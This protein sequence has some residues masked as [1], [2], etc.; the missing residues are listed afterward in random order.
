MKNSWRVGS[1]GKTLEQ[2]LRKS[3]EVVVEQIGMGWAWGRGRLESRVQGHVLR[4]FT[5]PGS[6]HPHVKLSST[7]RGLAGHRPH[8]R[9]SRWLR[10][11]RLDVYPYINNI[12]IQTR[13][14]SFRLPS[15]TAS[16]GSD[17]R[18]IPSKCCRLFSEWTGAPW[19]GSVLGKGWRGR[20]VASPAVPQPRSLGEGPWTEHLGLPRLLRWER[21]TDPQVCTNSD[22]RSC[23]KHLPRGRGVLN[24][25]LFHLLSF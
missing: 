20:D 23:L 1:G 12:I 13:L 22:Q 17:T 16:Q 2:L 11:K 8:G 9:G 15:P 7:P 3:R 5:A 6:R 19:I 10:G 4:V 21:P 25:F 18:L 14:H 24:K